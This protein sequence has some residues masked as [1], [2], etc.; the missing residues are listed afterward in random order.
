MSTYLQLEGIRKSFGKDGGEYDVK[1]GFMFN[2][3]TG[4]AKRI[5]S[6]DGECAKQGVHGISPNATVVPTARGTRPPLFLAKKRRR[7]PSALPL[8]EQSG[9]G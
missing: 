6:E 5:K 9:G 8:F 4:E 7:G 3:R 1:D 2:K